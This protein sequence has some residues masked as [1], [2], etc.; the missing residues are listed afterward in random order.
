VVWA[1][2]PL[3][4]TADAVPEPLPAAVPG[5]W[6]GRAVSAAGAA[7]LPGPPG[8]RVAGVAVASGAEEA[9]LVVRAGAALAW[10]GAGSLPRA[11][12]VARSGVASAAGTELAVPARPASAGA[13]TGTAPRSA[14]VAAGAAAWG[15]PPD[16]GRA[17]MRATTGPVS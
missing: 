2:S 4:G 7:L 10:V 6:A 16:C 1:P 14:T 9:A 15:A 11:V 8:A 17:G 5:V 12:P 3:R 13:V